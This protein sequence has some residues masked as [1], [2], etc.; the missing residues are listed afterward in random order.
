MSS[1]S[2]YVIESNKPEERQY[3]EGAALSKVLAFSGVPC[4][5]LEA[6]NK[7][8]MDFLLRAIVPLTLAQQNNI[9]IIHFSAHGCDKGIALTSTESISWKELAMMLR[10]IQEMTGGRYLLA[11]SSCMGLAALNIPLFTD[12][13]MYGIVGTLKIVAW[14]DNVVAFAGFYH[15]LQKGYSIPQAVEGM[16]S[17][18]GNPDYRYAHSDT[19][20]EEHRRQLVFS[21]GLGQ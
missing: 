3:S 12:V 19:F 2:V 1:F 18:S 16:K 21:S 9:P 20:I 17:A 5:Y 14:S 10:P 11:M 15:L 8:A 13:K 4:T 6:P 7:N